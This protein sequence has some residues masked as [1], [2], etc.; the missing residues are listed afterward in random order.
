MHILVAVPPG[1]GPGSMVQFTT[2]AGV[3]MQAAVPQGVL[4]G[5]QFSVAIAQAPPGTVVESQNNAFAA[6]AVTAISGGLGGFA[7]QHGAQAN[8]VTNALVCTPL[9]MEKVKNPGDGVLVPCNFCG[10]TNRTKMAMGSR[11]Q[12]NCGNCQALVLW[13]PRQIWLRDQGLP[14]EKAIHPQPG[15]TDGAACCLLM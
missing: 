6:G 1:S 12:F 8:A 10:A 13:R 15:E 7:A 9:G 11:A 5:Q 2:P 14:M 3:V 4:E